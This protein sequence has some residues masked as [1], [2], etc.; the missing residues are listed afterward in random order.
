MIATEK[1]S[2]LLSFL[3]VCSLLHSQQGPSHH[4]RWVG[5]LRRVQDEIGI[6]RHM[7]MASTFLGGAIIL[8][9]SFQKDCLNRSESFYCIPLEAASLLM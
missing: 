4:Q 2:S 7:S 9:G 3:N 6:A 5:Q 1:T 8:V